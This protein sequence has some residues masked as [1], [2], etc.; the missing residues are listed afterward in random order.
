MGEPTGHSE[1]VDQGTRQREG[2]EEEKVPQE[3]VRVPQGK[4]LKDQI[5]IKIGAA[6][7]EIGKGMTSGDADLARVVRDLSEAHTYLRDVA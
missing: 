5:K 1:E 3:E 6:L 2:Q 7:D 4:E